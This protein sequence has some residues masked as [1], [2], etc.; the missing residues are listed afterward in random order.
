M[1]KSKG[2]G[3]SVDAVEEDGER[4]A[5]AATIDRLNAEVWFV[6]LWNSSI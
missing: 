6:G 5:D 4:A 3:E 2:N 1:Q